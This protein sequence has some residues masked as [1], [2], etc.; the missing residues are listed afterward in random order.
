M[1]FILILIS[2]LLGSIPFGFLLVKWAGKGDI[3]KVSSGST[4]ATNVGRVIGTRG[5]VATWVLDMAKAVAAF[6]IGQ[7]F[8]GSDFGALCGAV[9]VIGHIFPVWLKFKGGKGFAPIWG[10]ILALNPIAFAALGII[11][12]RQSQFSP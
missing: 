1:H 10:F 4:G 5:F 2:Y 6:M 12:L 7:Y 8:F 9:A 3:R 11:W